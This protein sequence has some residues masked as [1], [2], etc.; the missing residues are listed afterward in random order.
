MEDALGRARHLLDIALTTYQTHLAYPSPAAEF[1]SSDEKLEPILDWL[2]RRSR[3]KPVR[4]AT[5]LTHRPKI[6]MQPAWLRRLGPWPA[7][8][9]VQ[10]LSPAGT[11]GVDGL[12]TRTAEV[13]VFQRKLP[14]LTILDRQVA[15][16]RTT[17]AYGQPRIFAVHNPEI[18]RGF[19]AL[20][21]VVW[22][23]AVELHK[24]RPHGIKPDNEMTAKVLGLLGN[25]CKDEAAAR[26]LGLS[27]RTYRRHVA[28]LMTRL[29]VS[30][31]FQAGVQA[32]RLGLISEEPGA[33]SGLTA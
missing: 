17:A 5:V 21:D 4:L 9:T 30:C 26:Q 24:F 31:R 6:E 32:V 2:V 20:Y 1:Y 23:E 11:T 15:I 25:G 14:D 29:H 33:P 18:V 10:A 22:A 27:V 13:R 19:C 7:G 3:T 12:D 8:S 16:L 28:D